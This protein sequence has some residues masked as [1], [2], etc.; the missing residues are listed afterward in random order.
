MALG[1]VTIASTSRRPPQRAQRRTSAE[2]VRLNN[3]DHDSLVLG[4]PETTLS[5]LEGDCASDIGSS[6]VPPTA[7]GSGTAE[8]GS[9]VP[10]TAFG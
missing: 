3:S 7:F 6:E 8:F 9:G 2:K 10:P 5:L 1:R 4:R